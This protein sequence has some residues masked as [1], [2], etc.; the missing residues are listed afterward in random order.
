MHIFRLIYLTFPTLQNKLFG[1][2]AKNWYVY[3]SVGNS[4][5]PAPELLQAPQVIDFSKKKYYGLGIG[6]HRDI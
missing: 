3:I 4:R 2:Y 5:L 6:A 1:S